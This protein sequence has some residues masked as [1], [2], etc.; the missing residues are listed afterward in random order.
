MTNKVES[1]LLIEDDYQLA[2]EWQN[3]L[4]AKG[5][6][7]DIAANSSDAK[8]LLSNDYDCFVIDL[9][10]VQNNQFLPDGGI[11]SI[12]QIRKRNA[13]YNKKSLIIAVTGF[14]REGNNTTISTEEIVQSLGANITLKK[15]IDIHQIIKLI[16]EWEF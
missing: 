8:I 10:H 11:R 1:I 12:G 4:L 16:E 13:S 3:E 9:F 14:F 6:E 15:P 2:T 5:Y 7:V